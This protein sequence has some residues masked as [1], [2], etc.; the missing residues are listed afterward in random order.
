LLLTIL[1]PLVL[2]FEAIPGKSTFSGWLQSMVF[3][4]L[5]FP[6][7]TIIVLLSRSIMGLDLSTSAAIWQPPGVGGL[8]SQSFQTLIGAA[9]IFMAPDLIKTF[10]QLSG[11]K[12]MSNDVNLMGLFAGGMA[13]GSTASG[14]LGKAQSFHY[15][16]Q[17]LKSLGFGKKEEEH[18]K[19]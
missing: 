19:T 3:H 18:A 11:I 14:L 16:S 7:L 13:V 5:T 8:D 10:K 2:A 1:S 4:L 6:A 17:G 12:P 9:L 15:M